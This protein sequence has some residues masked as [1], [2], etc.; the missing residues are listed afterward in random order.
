M[1]L[2]KMDKRQRHEDP[3]IVEKDGIV[4]V[5]YS[6]AFGGNGAASSDTMASDFLQDVVFNGRKPTW[7]RLGLV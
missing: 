7:S 6:Q 2:G 4:L 1:T 5:R 3:D